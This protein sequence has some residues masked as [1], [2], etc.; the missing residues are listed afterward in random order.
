MAKCTLSSGTQASTE[1]E[2]LWEGIDF[3]TSIT[4]AG[5]EE[6]TLNLLHGTMDSV[7][8]AFKVPNSTSQRSVMLS[9]WAVLS[10]SPRFRSLGKTASV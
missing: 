1:I 5:F 6:L 4:H 3:Y 10:K 8:K 9:W 7:E 2:S